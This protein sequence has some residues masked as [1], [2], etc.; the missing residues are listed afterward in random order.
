MKHEEIFPNKSH[1]PTFSSNALEG[2][3]HRIPGLSEQFLFLNDDF[4]FGAP[5]SFDDFYSD[6]GHKVLPV[7]SGLSSLPVTR[8]L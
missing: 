5:V 1:L 7:V 8:Q 2:H 4:I 6:H 3:L